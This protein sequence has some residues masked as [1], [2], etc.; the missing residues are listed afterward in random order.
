MIFKDD[1]KDLFAYCDDKYA[2]MCVRHTYIP[3]KD[4]I[5]MDG[6]AQRFYNRKNWSSFVLWNCGHPAN[7]D[8]TPEKVNF[9]PGRELHAFCWLNDRDIGSLPYEYNYISGISPTLPIDAYPS[10]IHY[11]DGGP[12][13]DECTNVDF[14]QHWIDEYEDW[15]KEGQGNKYSDIPTMRYE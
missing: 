6:R 10:V 4:S 14:A 7:K 3:S 13:F 1:I 11:T 2:V 12:W 5:K 9:L 8:I 15:Q